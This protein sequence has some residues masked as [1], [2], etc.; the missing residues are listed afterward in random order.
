LRWAGYDRGVNR[1]LVIFLVFVA[2]LLAT[3]LAVAWWLGPQLTLL[4]SE[5]LREKSVVFLDFSNPDDRDHRAG[6]GEVDSL[7]QLVLGEN[8]K[9]LYQGTDAELLDGRLS[10]DDWQ[11]LTIY[12]LTAGGDYLRL[13]TDPQFQTMEKAASA[14]LVLAAQPGEMQGLTSTPGTVRVIWLLARRGGQSVDEVEPFLSTVIAHG[15][16]PA[17]RL[18]VARLEGSRDWDLALAFDFPSSSLALA[19]HRDLKTRTELTIMRARY[20]STAGLLFRANS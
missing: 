8:G 13:R 14:R 4:V 2:S 10:T 3:G 19:W 16:S 1:H 7:D 20:R 12:S 11:K 15:G 6:S 5:D 17:M 18:E 9:V